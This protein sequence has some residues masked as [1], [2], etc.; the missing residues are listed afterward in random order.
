MHPFSIGVYCQLAAQVYVLL[1]G[2][3]IKRHAWFHLRSHIKIVFTFFNLSI[4]NW[5]DKGVTWPFWLGEMERVSMTSSKSVPITR[6]LP[7]IF[8]NLFSI[9]DTILLW[10][11]TW[12]I[13]LIVTVIHTILLMKVNAAVLENWVALLFAFL[14]TVLANVDSPPK[15]ITLHSAL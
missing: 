12:L 1:H 4:T 3:P 2:R 14:M 11:Y 13:D 5:V 6:T 9:H 10:Y 8:D 15:C 7:P